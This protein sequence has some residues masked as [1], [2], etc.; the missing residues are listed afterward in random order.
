MKRGRRYAWT[1]KKSSQSAEQD[2]SEADLFI[3]I[4]IIGLLGATMYV[5][6]P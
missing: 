4:G 2:M 3:G 6:A 5:F 1:V